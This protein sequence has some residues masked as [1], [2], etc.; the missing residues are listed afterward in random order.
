MN[1]KDNLERNALQNFITEYN[2]THKRQLY[3]IHQCK[4]PM[5]DTLCQLDK[6][7]IGIEVVHNYGTDEEAAVRL[8]NLSSENIP[9]HIHQ[10]RRQIPLNIRALHFLNRILRK[11][12]TKTYSFTPTWLLIRNGFAL[13]SLA[14]YRKHKLEIH[15]PEIHPFKQV[16][17]LFDKHS[18]GL[19]GIIRL[20]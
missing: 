13:W 12:G 1:Q 18:V 2:R 5:P 3:F 17:F 20:A 8:G 19:S 15:V 7:K 4:P 9:K 16:W 14:D 11:K 6:R 10:Q